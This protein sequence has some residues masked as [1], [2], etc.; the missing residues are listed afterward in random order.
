MRLIFLLKRIRLQYQQL[1]LMCNSNGTTPTPQPSATP[2]L[3]GALSWSVHQ[4][5]PAPFDISCC[6][7]P[8]LIHHTNFSLTG[9]VGRGRGSNS[10]QFTINDQHVLN[11]NHLIN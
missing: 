4:D 10:L 1:N 8:F 2:N 9:G 3:F 7:F 6:C 11:V 5:S